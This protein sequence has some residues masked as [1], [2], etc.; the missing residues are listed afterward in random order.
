MFARTHALKRMAFLYAYVTRA[1]GADVP[2]TRYGYILNASVTQAS[3]EY[4]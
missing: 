1:R 2:S 3:Y 4:W